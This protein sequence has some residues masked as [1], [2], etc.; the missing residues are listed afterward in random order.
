V[1]TIKIYV[2]FAIGLVQTVAAF[3]QVFPPLQ[4][5]PHTITVIPRTFFQVPYIAHDFT[6]Y[7]A[8][9]AQSAVMRQ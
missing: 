5:D 1:S 6:F 8:M 4:L 3:L 9:L 2:N 7:R